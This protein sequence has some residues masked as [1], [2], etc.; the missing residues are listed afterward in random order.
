MV[1]GKVSGRSRDRPHAR[2]DTDRSFV[3]E[4]AR[5]REAGLHST[6][7]SAGEVR[8]V[9]VPVRLPADDR[10][11]VFV[12]GEFRDRMKVFEVDLVVA[13][14]GSAAL[15]A[16]VLAGGSIWLIAGQV[17]APMRLVRRTAEEI[18][19]S[20]LTVRIATEGSE[21]SNDDVVLLARTFNAMLDRLEQAFT[22]QRHFLDDVGHELRT[23]I[24]VIRGHLET[25]SDDPEDRAQTITLVIDELQRMSRIVE[26]LTILAKADRPDFLEWTE[27]DPADL[28]IDVL[29][30]V[31]VLG[32]RD[33]T[34]DEVAHCSLRGDP[35]RLTQAL[36]Q[37]VSNSVRYTGEGDVIALG[38]RAD[39]DVVRFWVRDTGTGIPPDVT[40]RLFDRFVRIGPRSGAGLGLAIVRAIADAHGGRASL[41]STQAAADGEPGGPSGTTVTLEVPR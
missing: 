16:M 11:A 14:L 20:D 24:T 29:A 10:T 22:T 39:S 35:Q 38:C 1:D 31:R 3:R 25:M 9:T 5:T 6:E 23:P 8:Y 40:D 34:L 15:G 17:L 27:L 32:E 28:T 30:K 19:D 18:S 4:V 21:R 7:T 13:L 12:A 33:W 37:L 41:G 2:L 26:D 36:V